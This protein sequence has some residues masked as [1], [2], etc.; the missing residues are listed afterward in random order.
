MRAAPRIPT[1][2]LA[3]GFVAA[4]LLRLATLGSYPLIDPTEGRYAEIPREMVATGDWIVPHLAPDEPFWA[5]PP[6]SF[7]ATALAY[8]AFG[9]SEVTAR[10]GS[11]L[12]AAATLLCTA[13]AALRLLGPGTA[14]P[15]LAVLGTTG[16][17]Y[18]LAGSVLPEPALCAAVTLSATSLALATRGEAPGRR[19]PWRWLFFVGLGLGAMAKGAVAVVLPMAMAGVWAALQ[20]QARAALRRLPWIR[21][22]LLAALLTVPWHLAAEARSPGFLE[23]YLWG[24]HVQRFLVPD[25]HG[26]YGHSHDHPPG[27]IWLYWVLGTL[28]WLPAVLWATPRAAW[29]AAWSDPWRCYLWIWILVPPAFF[30]LARNISIPYVLVSL[31]PFALWTVSALGWTR[32]AMTEEP[33]QLGLLP[34]ALLLGLV[35]AIWLVVSIAILPGVGE[36]RS[37]RTLVRA[38]ERLSVSPDFR[39]VYLGRMPGSAPFYARG[40]AVEVRDPSSPRL[41]ELLTDG[42]PDFVALRSDDVQS[43]PPRLLERTQEVGRYGRYD[44]RAEPGSLRP[45]R[46]R[47]SQGATRLPAPRARSRSRSE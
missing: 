4:V 23:Y 21:G 41:A 43:A 22:S 7:W 37:Q 25:W 17:F 12:F 26:L 36:R 28:P 6:L 18:V 16:L 15:A 34:T 3:A 8:A 38:V 11:V 10:L 13:L 33:R 47:G 27:T 39:I 40:A 9:I 31:P 5:K 44:L 19:G 2:W 46:G 29:R 24:E 20:P 1:T 42:R 14:L 32:A 35:P 30:T 45:D